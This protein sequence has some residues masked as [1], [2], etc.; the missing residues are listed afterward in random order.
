MSA[1]KNTPLHRI[2]PVRIYFL[3]LV[4]LIIF[5]AS[6][7]IALR[8]RFDM[9]ISADVRKDF[10]SMLPWILIIKLSMFHLI[11]SLHGWW[12]YITFTDLA[13]LLRTS[14]VASILIAAVDYLFSQQYQIPRSVLLMDWGITILLVGGLRSVYRLSQEMMWPALSL[15][16]RKPTLLIGALQG[17]E[18]LARQIHNHPNLDFHIV[19]FLDDDEHK[20]GLRLGGIPFLGGPED[21]VEHARAHDA[22]DLLVISNVLPGQQLREL[23]DRC[24]RAKIRVKMVPPVDELINGSFRFQTRDVEINDLLRRDPIELD[25]QPVR[26]ML[27]GRRV[28]VTGAGGSIGSEICRQIARC[29]PAQLILVERA[30]NALFLIDR[31]MTLR[32]YGDMCVPFVADICDQHRMRTLFENYQPEIVFHAAAHKHVPLMELNPSRALKNNVL[33]TAGLVEL[34]HEYDVERFVM[35]ST[36]KAVNPTSIMGVSKQL[37]ERF[38]HAKAEV[39]KTKFVVVRF[40]NVLASAGSVVPIFQ[41]QIANGGPITITHPEMTRFFMTIPEASQLVLQASSMGKGG[42][43]FVLDMGKQVKILDLAKD[44][45]RLSGLD[46]DDIKIEYTGIRPGEKLYEELYMKHEE[47]MPTLHPKVKTAYHQSFS[48]EEIR[49]LMQKLQS[50]VGEDDEVIRKTMCEMAI[51][52]QYPENEQHAE[53][54]GVGSDDLA[55]S[56]EPIG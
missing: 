31:E 2:L 6:Y 25:S 3:V 11:G 8:L 43:I 9:V 56:A 17:G 36:D 53:N 15:N 47:M 26:E 1:K 48:C 55:A 30:E 18:L 51:A 12:R 23:L 38:V 32:D 54:A 28:V 45:I 16:D 41:E 5:I 40:G 49:S 14:T 24:E 42:E 13:I 27:Q 33:G 34:C 37:A 50:L 46:E 35:I 4:H 20:H 19:G 44:L 22:K 52:F 10:W 21:I 39:S 7:E 29:E